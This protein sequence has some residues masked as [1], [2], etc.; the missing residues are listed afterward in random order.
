MKTV[1]GVLFALLLVSFGQA[2][3]RWTKTYGGTYD[4]YGY[5]VQQDSDSGYVITGYTT[6]FG[7][8]YADVY[9]VKTDASGDT[10]WTRTFGG[11]Q[12]DDGYSVRQTSDGG[13]IIAGLTYSFGAG[14]S[15]V[16]LI[17]TNASGDTLWTRT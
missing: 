16:Y 5:S 10:L 1:S 6:S 11:T 3:Q 13:Y 12:G 9:L 4:D 2:Q 14:G 17:K 7:A 8:G 15:D